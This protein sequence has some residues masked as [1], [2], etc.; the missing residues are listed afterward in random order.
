MKDEYVFV[1]GIWVELN[2]LVIS[3]ILHCPNF[4]EDDYEKLMIE[5]VDIEAPECQLC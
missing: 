4:E 5:E 2:Q 1:R 3:E